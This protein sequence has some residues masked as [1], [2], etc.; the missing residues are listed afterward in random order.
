M[1]K[2]QENVFLYQSQ[3]FKMSVHVSLKL[4]PVISC[5]D[6]QTVSAKDIQASLLF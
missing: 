4:A 2:L 1:E 3:C 5:P 6:K